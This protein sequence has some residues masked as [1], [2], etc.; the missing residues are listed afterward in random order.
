[1]YVLLRQPIYNA[2]K[3]IVFYE[4]FLQDS[5]TGKYP[6]DMDPLK[7]TSITIDIIIELTP[8]KVGSGKKVFVNVPAI[9]LEA[10]MFELL[11]P[12]YVG[13][14]LVENKSI[15]N[16]L[17]EAIN[18]LVEAGYDLSIDDFGYENINY[19]PLVNKCSYVKINWQQRPKDL[20]ELKAV[21]DSLKD[22][23]KKVIVKNIETEEDF[24]QAVLL[25]FDYFQGFYL[26]K[27]QPVRDPR[28]LNML[29]TTIIQLYEAIK[30]EDIKKITDIIEKDVGATFKL[31]KFVNSVYFSRIR[32]IS[33]VEEAVSYL[34]LNNIANFVLAIAI[35]EMFTTEE[36]QDLWKRSLNRALL[37]EYLAD[38]YVPHLKQKAYMVGLFS[39]IGDVLGSTP[40]DIA[41]ELRLDPDIVEAFETRKNELGFLLSIVELIEDKKEEEIIDKIAKVLNTTPKKIEDAITKAREETESLFSLL[42]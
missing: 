4:V 1:M 24:N 17:L 26:S 22:M 19:I 31:L 5:T 11:P 37:A 30:N 20:Y 38:I 39:L 9:F 41:R 13:I 34:G 21:I 36:D 25:G 23:D 35:S 27:P 10:S 33:S 32:K 14:E 12:E 16:Q 3:E 18:T 40:E 8:S 6:P 42:K 7:A 29:R 15:T 2:N 28:T